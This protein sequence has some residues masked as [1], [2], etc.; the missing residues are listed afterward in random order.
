S[1][2]WAFRAAI[3]AER[4]PVRRLAPL[5]RREVAELAGDLPEPVARVCAPGGVRR[6]V[7][8][9]S[10]LRMRMWLLSIILLR[11]LAR[12]VLGDAHVELHVVA[13]HG[14]AEGG[15]VCARGEAAE[16]HVD[17]VRHPPDL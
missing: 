14:G 13:V 1:E 2:P 12:R 17:L 16:E 15:I 10:Q 4:R 6:A 3:P 9:K 8:S 11:G 7:P 5:R